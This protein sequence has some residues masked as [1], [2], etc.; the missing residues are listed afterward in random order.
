LSLDAEREIDHVVGVHR[1]AM[2]PHDLLAVGIDPLDRDLISV[3][4]TRDQRGRHERAQRTGLAGLDAVDV[5]LGIRRDG[6]FQP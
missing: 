2:G 1:H 6:D 3:L 4:A 5:D